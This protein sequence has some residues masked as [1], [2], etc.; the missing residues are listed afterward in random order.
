M[1]IPNMNRRKFFKSVFSIIAAG[2]CAPISQYLEPQ[3]PYIDIVMTSSPVVAKPRKLKTTWVMEPTSAK[4]VIYKDKGA[5]I[6]YIV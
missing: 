5:F 6:D 1:L 4:I 2:F 3:I